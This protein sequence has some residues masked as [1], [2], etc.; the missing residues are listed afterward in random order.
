MA[1]EIKDLYK[2]YGNKSI[3]DGFS[4][5]FDEK[6]LY[7]ID[8]VS[9]AGKTTLL[10]IISGL[11]RDYKGSVEGGGIKNTSFVFQEYRLF[12]EMTA[13]DNIAC[14]S[15]KKASAKDIAA[16]SKLLGDLNFTNDEKYLYPSELSGGMKQRVNFARAILKSSPILI[17]DEPTKEIDPELVSKMLDIVSKE[18]TK[19]LVLLVTHNKSELSALEYT[20]VELSTAD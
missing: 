11:D 19:R 9:G 1:L 10:R 12:P 4:Y 3:L 8:G 16:A 6:G 7:V 17:L 18:A 15:F 5:K 2:S 14:A 13:I 20:T